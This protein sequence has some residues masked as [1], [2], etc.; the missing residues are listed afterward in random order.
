MF[1]LEL[2]KEDIE[3][4]RLRILFCRFKKQIL[5]KNMVKIQCITIPIVNPI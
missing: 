3:K 4:K 2:T 1:V 5:M